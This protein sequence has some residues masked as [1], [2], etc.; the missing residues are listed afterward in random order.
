MPS[1][2]DIS[3]YSRSKIESLAHTFTSESKDLNDYLKRFSYNHSIT[4]STSKT[5]LLVKNEEILSYITLT[6]ETISDEN[7]EKYDSY[8]NHANLSEN[9]SFSIPT[10]KIARLATDTKHCG[11]N[12]GS[13]LIQLAMIKSF[14][15]QTDVGCNMLTVDSKKKAI[16]FYKKNGFIKIGLD[17]SE[18]TPMLRPIERIKRLT[19]SNKKEILEVCSFFNLT[20]DRSKLSNYFNSMY[21][22]H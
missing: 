2:V 18:T 11:N 3:T 22:P 20:D 6:M 8:K 9:F 16:G 15:L 5:Y 7:K 12:Y 10:L 21:N 19:D 14:I 17:E 4:T 13:I 1:L